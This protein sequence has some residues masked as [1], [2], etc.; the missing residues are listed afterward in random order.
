MCRTNCFL[1][2]QIVLRDFYTLMDYD[3]GTLMVNEIGNIDW[4]IPELSLYSMFVIVSIAQLLLAP[5]VFLNYCTATSIE[6]MAKS[7]AIR[8]AEDASLHK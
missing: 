6:E 7:W 4:V 8:K 3:R 1:F 2:G 5:S